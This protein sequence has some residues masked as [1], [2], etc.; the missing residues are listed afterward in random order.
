MVQPEHAVKVGIKAQAFPRTAYQ[1]PKPCVSLCTL[2]K[3][4]VL[5]TG[6][7]GIQSVFPFKKPMGFGSNRRNPFLAGLWLWPIL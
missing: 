1:N 5:F 7:E 6:N 4:L 3:S 2:L